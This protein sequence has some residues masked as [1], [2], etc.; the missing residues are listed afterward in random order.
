MA[1]TSTA[2]S[3]NSWAHHSTDDGDDY[4]PGFS[5]ISS[6]SELHND[7]VVTPDGFPTL[8]DN[9]SDFSDSFSGNESTTLLK[10]ATKTTI[11]QEKITAATKTVQNTAEKSRL[12][13]KPHQMQS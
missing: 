7:E 6:F 10:S 9:A 5:E 3:R 4:S 1:S 8:D 2:D 12:K 11:N 13:K